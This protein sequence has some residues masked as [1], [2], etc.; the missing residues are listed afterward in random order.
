MQ[1]YRDRVHHGAVSVSH[2][3]TGI[4]TG[5]NVGEV[6][7][8]TQSINDCDHLQ[9]HTVVFPGELICVTRIFTIRENGKDASLLN[10]ICK[11]GMI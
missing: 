6:L 8:A 2:T 11:W 9:K 10:Q 4:R 1:H 5:S 3:R 7:N